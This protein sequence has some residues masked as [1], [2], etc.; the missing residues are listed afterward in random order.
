VTKVRRHDRKL[1]GI[2]RAYGRLCQECVGEL[3]ASQ[4]RRQDMKA[5]SE[6][7]DR[8]SEAKASPG[9]RMRGR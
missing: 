7:G 3:F 5:A 6:Q 2:G 4:S 1:L 9:R 8:E